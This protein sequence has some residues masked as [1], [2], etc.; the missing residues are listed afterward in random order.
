[1]AS[2]PATTARGQDRVTKDGAPEVRDHRDQRWKLHAQPLEMIAHREVQELVAVELP[3]RVDE[4]QRE[5]DAECDE[6]DR[7]RQEVAASRGL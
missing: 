1:M 6:G 4:Q 5:R 7:D 2:T 3:R